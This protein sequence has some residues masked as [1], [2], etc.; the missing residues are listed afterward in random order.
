MNIG[1]D[2]LKELLHGVV[3]TEERDGK[4][5]LHR[6]TKEQ[7]EAYKPYNAD[8]YKKTFGS[9]GIT[10]E[11]ITDSTTFALSAHISSASSRKFFSFDVYENGNLIKTAEGI[12]PDEQTDFDFS[13]TL[14]AG[15]KVVTIYFPWSVVT[16][17][18]SVSVDDSAELTPIKKS[19]K[20]ISFGDSITHGYDAKN[21]SFSYASRLADALRADIVNKGIGGEVFFP[22]L[23]KLKDD[24]EPDYITVAYGTN[25]WSRCK[26]KQGKDN[27]DTNCK[28]FY[29]ALSANY[30]NSK[31]FAITPIWRGDFERDTQVVPFS[32]INEYISKVTAEL[33]NV[34]VING[35]ELVPHDKSCYIADLLHPNCEGFRH[36]AY[37]L[38]AEIKK[39]L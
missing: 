21:P 4:L 32:Y 23:A 28:E 25:D 6:F 27:F 3:Y 31:I 34:T 20:I 14:G 13:A 8:Y 30:P 5:I 26:D 29:E 19:Y 39:Y 22:P 10:L 33:P 36:Y 24:I 35:F 37:N 17:I 11:F 9:A 1:F 18:Y 38:Y 16:Q 2:K 7:E 12:L 15:K